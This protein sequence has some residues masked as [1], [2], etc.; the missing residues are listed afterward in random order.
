MAYINHHFNIAENSWGLS[1]FL[2]SWRRIYN[3]DPH[4]AP[5]YHPNI[6]QSLD[7]R[8]NAH[9]ARLS[10]L[11]VHSTALPRRSNSDPHQ[12]EINVEGI[13]F[14]KPVAAGILLKDPRRNDRSAHLVE[15]RCV[16]DKES[17]ERFLEYLGVQMLS[18]D[19]NQLICPVGL[20]PYIR[21]GSLESHW[22]RTPPLYT[23]Y[24]PPYLPEM[25][26]S[27]M[28]PIC[29][30]RLYLFDLPEELPPAAEKPAILTPLNPGDLSNEVPKLIL[31]LGPEISQIYQPSNFPPPDDLEI[32]FLMQWVK[33]WPTF[34]WLAKINDQPVGCVVLQPD[35]APRLKQAKGGKSP[36]WRVWLEM[37]KHDAASQGRVV[38]GGVH[39]AWQGHGI[40]RQLISKTL[41][42]AK[43]QGWRQVSVGPLSQQYSE[44]LVHLGARPLQTYSLYKWK[45]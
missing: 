23:P 38:F 24:N 40:G 21:T 3:E 15:F 44:V 39:P 8:K 25:L 20:S 6:R 43:D 22:N 5:P 26:E 13:T 19:C 37:K 1:A 29:S 14:E 30:F 45:L 35:M 32:D 11:I 18:I 42:T 28:D 31:A 12:V 17:L 27:T 2:S 16:N 7:S 36:L 9:L 33:K 41:I 4:L 34:G 10:T